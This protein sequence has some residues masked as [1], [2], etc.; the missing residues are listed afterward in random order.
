[1]YYLYYQ[2]TVS[3]HSHAQFNEIKQSWVKKC[4]ILQYLNIY[5]ESLSAI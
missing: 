2:A 4:Q 1:M 3:F 5:Y